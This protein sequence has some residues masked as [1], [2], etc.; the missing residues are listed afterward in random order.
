MQAEASSKPTGVVP[1]PPIEVTASSFAAGQREHMLEAI[2]GADLVAIDTE[3]TGLS[4]ERHLAAV[5]NDTLESRYCRYRNASGAIALT[6]VGICTLRWDEDQAAWRAKP[7]SVYVVPEQASRMISAE[8]GAL[9]FLRDNAFDFG[10]FV[11][12]VEYKSLYD[13]ERHREFA[14]RSK[15]AN[16]H[17]PFGT[18]K[19]EDVCEELVENVD[20]IAGW[21]RGEAPKH[22]AGALEAK[23]C[24]DEARGLP[25]LVL[26]PRGGKQRKII[27]DCLGVAFPGVMA[28]DSTE[29]DVEA[30]KAEAVSKGLAEP[31]AFLKPMRLLRVDKEHDAVARWT[32]VE[33]L[34]L[35]NAEAWPPETLP[36]SPAVA[37]LKEELLAEDLATIGSRGS[38]FSDV[39][40]AISERGCPVIVHNGMLDAVHCMA[41]FVQPLPLMP[42]HFSQA[43]QHWMPKLFDTKSLLSN[44]PLL[45]RA[46]ASTGLGAAFQEASLEP[47]SDVVVVPDGDAVAPDGVAPSVA[48]DAGYDAWMTASLF[49][50]V[51]GRLGLSPRSIQSL[52]ELPL[53][54]GEAIEAADQAM[55]ERWESQRT[56]GQW[57]FSQKRLLKAKQAGAPEGEEVALSDADLAELGPKPELPERSL[58]DPSVLLAAHGGVL[59]LMGMNHGGPRAWRLGLAACDSCNS[60][61]DPVGLKSTVLHITGM[62]DSVRNDDVVAMI[63]VAAERDVEPL[64][65]RDVVRTSSSSCFVK[66]PDVECVRAVMTGAASQHRSV[67]AELP[68][69]FSPSALPSL[70]RRVLEEYAT[71]KAVPLS[72]VIAADNCFSPARWRNASLPKL[73]AFAVETYSSFLLRHS[74]V[75]PPSV[76]GYEVE[77]LPDDL[78]RA[79]VGFSPITGPIV[80]SALKRPRAEE[81]DDGPSAKRG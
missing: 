36:S 13:A 29:E 28:V 33:Q 48:H 44:E 61:P 12:G 37:A 14:T 21:L 35:G 64:S 74:D 9:K 53:P 57:E 72:A 40:A 54:S 38:G 26:P 76:C 5:G 3:F 34:S 17:R 31:P 4:S 77:G 58:T 51:M 81:C 67:L 22:D 46:V 25:A 10:R 63:R 32:T 11:N 16:V 62:N 65:W 73:G 75:F 52:R 8:T 19:F 59:N 2:R 27:H 56:L 23:H 43:L 41:A 68:A 49:V 80:P 79:S 7:F 66:L 30:F 20:V 1:C 55:R 6:E 50:R 24:V 70:T 15:V 71:G 45:F 39:F 18:I 42:D 60:W 69:S 47:F 78:R